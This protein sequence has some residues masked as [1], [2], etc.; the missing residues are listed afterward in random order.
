MLNRVMLR[1]TIGLLGMLI[2][3]PLLAD[4]SVSLPEFFQRVQET[5]VLGDCQILKASYQSNHPNFR[6]PVVEIEAIQKSTQQKLTGY[7]TQEA[8]WTDEDLGGGGPYWIW[9]ER[10]Y[11]ERAFPWV[12]VKRL[13]DYASFKYSADGQLLS[14]ELSLWQYK[15]T[16]IGKWY[17]TR[18]QKIACAY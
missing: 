15:K 18:I 7:F 2:S 4:H 17:W 12:K 10:P 11:S 9:T 5:P 1:N 3:M 16:A 14:F 13:K 6:E 8:Y